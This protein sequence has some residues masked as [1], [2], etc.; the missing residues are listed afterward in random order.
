MSKRLIIILAVAFM[1]GLSLAAYAEVQNVKVSGDILMRAISRSD[2]TLNPDVNKYKASGITS[3][4]RVRVDADLTDNVSTTIRLLNERSWGD[5]LNPMDAVLTDEGVDV[6]D[7]WDISSPYADSS[8]LGSE[9][10]EIDLAYVTLKEFLY[11]PLTL[12]I[13]RQ[14]LRFGNALIIGDVDTNMLSNSFAIPLDL[15]LKKSFDAIRAT[16]DYTPWVLDLVYSKIAEH[17]VW[18]ATNLYNNRPHGEM[19]RNDT[20]LYGINASLDTKN[21]LGIEGKLDLYYWLRRNLY[22]NSMWDGNYKKD[23]C[24]T[25]GAL[26]TGKILKNLTGNIEYAWQFGYVPYDITYMNDDN[27]KRQAFAIQGGLNYMIQSEKYKDKSPMVGIKYTYL[28]ADNKADGKAT[29]WDPMFEDQTPNN[30]VNAMF[31][32]TGTQNIN[33]LGSIK[34]TEDTTLA[35]NY[36]YYWLSKKPKDNGV[37]P[38]I[39]G[40]SPSSEWTLWNNDGKRALGSALDLTA[41]YDYTEDVQFGLTFGMFAPGKALKDA[42]YGSHPDGYEGT[43]TQLIGSMKVTF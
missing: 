4:V 1:L 9:D 27:A 15:S 32:N 26:L 11:S 30:L 3:Q 40:S 24:N 33:I 22:G 37:I 5:Q 23:E 7:P 21:A 29:M 19:E 34:P 42:E 43:A 38:A 28:S 36:G 16:L 6:G 12:T 20:D 10:F 18:W 17:D 39:Y 35:I 25:I 2:L 8:W 41:T 13:G 14:E 31:P